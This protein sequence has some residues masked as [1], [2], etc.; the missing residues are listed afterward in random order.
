MK[1]HQLPKTTTRKKIRLG[2][3]YGTG[4]GH[5]ST[6]GQKGQNARSGVSLWFEGGQL[7]LTKRIPFLR[8]KDRFKSLKR[9]PII[10]NLEQLEQFSA[11]ETITK[12]LLIDKGLVSLE[13]AAKK[14]IKILSRGK[15]T[16]AIKIEGLTASKKAQDKITKAG[17]QLIN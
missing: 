5:T 4:K 11:K 14:P 6:R 2:R 8:G 16:K 12:K 13:E 15:L 9:T 7:P 10:I 17:G 1:L 3:G